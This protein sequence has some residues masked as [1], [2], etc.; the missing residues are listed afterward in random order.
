M[1]CHSNVTLHVSPKKAFEGENLRKTSLKVQ[2]PFKKKFVSDLVKNK[3]KQYVFGMY[4]M[5][6]QLK[7]IF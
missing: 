6:N 1:K 5:T 2:I 7:L 4:F 3:L